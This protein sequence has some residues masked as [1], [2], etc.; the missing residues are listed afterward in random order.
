M[1]CKKEI[2]GLRNAK[3]HCRE[4]EEAHDSSLNLLGNE[5]FVSKCHEKSSIVGHEGISQ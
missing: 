5:M 3:D 2:I 4:G 1:S